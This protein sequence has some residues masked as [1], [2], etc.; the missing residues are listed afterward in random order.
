MTAIRSP[1]LDA[2]ALDAGL[3]PAATRLQLDA[4]YGAMCSHEECLAVST[5]KGQVRDAVG[6]KDCAQMLAVGGDD[7]HSAGAAA[8]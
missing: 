7:P 3:L 2:E 4:E 1:G 5:P 8:V 6:R